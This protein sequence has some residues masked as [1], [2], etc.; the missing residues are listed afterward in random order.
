M[1]GPVWAFFAEKAQWVD[2]VGAAIHAGPDGA[3]VLRGSRAAV[4]VRVA[5]THPERG[6]HRRLQLWAVH[7]VR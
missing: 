5:G 7:S 1:F 6:V 2:G 3:G 4:D